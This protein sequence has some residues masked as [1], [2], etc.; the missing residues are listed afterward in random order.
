MKNKVLNQFQE[1]ANDKPLLIALA[2][3]LVICVGILVFLAFSISPSERQI[4]VHYTSFGTTNFYRDKWY[5]L[6]GFVGFVVVMAVVHC[7]L[8]YKMLR[9]KGRELA[10][11]F[12]WLGVIM[13]VIAVGFLVQIIKIASII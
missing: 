9:E 2:L 6:L 3:F 11:A 7:L 12:S 5:Y 10:V 1:I 4:A 8:T 13:A